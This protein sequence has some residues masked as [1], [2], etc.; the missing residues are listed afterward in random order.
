MTDPVD[1]PVEAKA[2]R[3][4]AASLVSNRDQIVHLV[5]GPEMLRSAARMLGPEQMAAMELYL[6]LHTR[7]MIEAGHWE[8]PAA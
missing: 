7:R 6:R 5:S 3:H 2:R 8:P 4:W 1:P